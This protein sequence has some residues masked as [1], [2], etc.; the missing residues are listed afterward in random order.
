M[1][2]E[3]VLTSQGFIVSVA[4]LSRG[5]GA[6]YPDL[7]KKLTLRKESRH[8]PAQ[9]I[10]MYTFAQV[11]GI[12]CIVLPRC[13]IKLLNLASLTIFLPEVQKIICEAR[14]NF[15]ES[16]IIICDNLIS[17]VFN[18]QRRIAGTACAI[19]NLRAGY[20]K[21]FCAAS[22]I[23]RL[24]V[25][26]LIIVPA[27][28][29]ANQMCKDLNTALD[30]KIAIY[31][32]VKATKAGSIKQDEPDILI[33]VIN[34]ALKLP[35]E[36]FAKFSFV[37]FDEVQTLCTEIRRIIFAK[38]TT[39]FMF[40]M[41]AT[42]EDRNDPFDAV[43]HKELAMDG[44]IRAENIPGFAY[45][46]AIDPSRKNAFDVDVTVI[47]YNG[48]AEFT[49]LICNETTGKPSTE[50]M[51]KQFMKDPY[52]VALCISCIKELLCWRGP[53]G[54]KHRIFVFCEEREP[55]QMFCD[56]LREMRDDSENDSEIALVT[57]DLSGKL[58]GG[59]KDTDAANI[60]KNARVI[61]T[62]YS[63]SGTG[64]SIVDATAIIF[65]SSRKSNMKQITARIMRMGSDKS[66]RRRIIDIVDNKTFLRNHLAFRMI[67]YEFYQMNISEK[68]LN[69]E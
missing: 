68:K 17:R 48:P 5:F 27:V 64:V 57:D 39:H 38:A 35:S 63:Y 66:I 15:Y 49:Q 43:A 24:K 50:K 61:L 53:E 20:G 4:R 3:G 11:R 69:Y 12:N 21:S 46:T 23:Q 42:T 47:K 40:G 37:I 2:L 16:Q 1:E 51:L 31:K 26:T 36:F 52:R 32:K 33:I 22:L 34:T 56:K 13:L 18:E 30:A 59:I 54:Q 44:I 19:L 67:A 45:E 62:T 29:L 41:S 14:I 7:L 6:R 55:L 65:T 9:V 28:N 10:K 8:G 58:I 60:L 25:R